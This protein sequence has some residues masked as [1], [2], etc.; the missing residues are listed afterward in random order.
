MV[1]LSDEE[2]IQFQQSLTA[3]VEYKEEEHAR[4]NQERN[5]VGRPKWTVQ[6]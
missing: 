3:T 1:M 6:P 5:G 4:S 2:G